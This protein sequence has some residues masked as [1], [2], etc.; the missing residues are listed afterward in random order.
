MLRSTEE[1][2]TFIETFSATSTIATSTDLQKK[3]FTK[4]YH[5]LGSSH[6]GCAILLISYLYT[7]SEAYWASAR[8]LPVES[9]SSAHSSSVSYDVSHGRLDQGKGIRRK[10]SQCFFIIMNVLRTC[11]LL[12][13]LGQPTVSYFIFLTFV[14]VCF[15]CSAVLPKDV[16]LLRVVKLHHAL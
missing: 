12:S 9:Y 2:P 10:H 4:L 5:V 15:Y 6:A 7:G 8:T 11:K 3:P 1:F 16:S 13:R 14:I